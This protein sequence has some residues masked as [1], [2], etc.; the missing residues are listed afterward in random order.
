MKT[1]TTPLTSTP[2][3]NSVLSAPAAPTAPIPVS[4]VG[5]GA[6]LFTNLL[7]PAAIEELDRL[8]LVV[9]VQNPATCVNCGC[10][11]RQACPGGCY[12]VSVNRD[13][14]TGVCS[15]CLSLR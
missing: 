8:A 6:G 9:D 15:S 3:V 11:D 14:A 5:H 1:K 4:S 13:D 2:D 12:W 7:D 10:T